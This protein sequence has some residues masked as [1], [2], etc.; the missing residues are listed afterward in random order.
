MKVEEVSKAFNIERETR[1]NV[2]SVA[3]WGTRWNGAG[4][5]RRKRIEELD[6]AGMLVDAE[7][8]KSSGRATAVAAT[9][10]EWRL[11]FH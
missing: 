10:T 11:L 2:P 5:N 4:P 9:T 1:N 3:N 6:A 7:P 8:I